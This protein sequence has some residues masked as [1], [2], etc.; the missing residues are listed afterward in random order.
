MTEWLVCSSFLLVGAA[1]FVPMVPSVLRAKLFFSLVLFSAIADSIAVAPVFAGDAT[2]SG[3]I[4]FG[5][6]LG[7]AVVGLE[8]LS[9]FF[10]MIVAW[11][12]LPAVALAGRFVPAGSG[13]RAHWFFL[14]LLLLS[15][16]LALVLD[17]LL[18]FLVV[19]EVM[20]LSSF[21][22]VL[23]GNSGQQRRSAGLHY[24]VA[25]HVSVVLLMLGAVFLP[26]GDMSFSRMSGAE[27]ALASFVL[28]MTG[29]AFKM[30]LV[31][32][33]SWIPEAY[34]AAAT[35]TSAIMSSLMSKLGVYGMLRTVLSGGFI[36][37]AAAW[38]VIVAGILSAVSGITFSVIRRDIKE[39]LSY[40]SME[41]LGII[42]TGIG[43]MMLG[44][45][46]SNACMMWA[47]LA[48]ALF[49]TLCH[50]FSKVVLFSAAGLVERAGVGRDI[51]SMGGLSRRMPR[52]SLVF[53]GTAWASASLPPFGGVISEILLVLSMV[54]G[55]STASPLA[56]TGLVLVL[57]LLAMTG[58]IA[59]LTW[60]RT[61]GIAFSGEPRS[62]AARSA[63]EGG[64]WE[65]GILWVPLIGL[66]CM[67]MFPALVLEW[68][69]PVMD[70]IAGATLF[71]DAS[72]AAWP[73][74][75]HTMISTLVSLS[76][77][78]AVFGGIVF[79]LLL[80][81]WL[82]LRKREQGEATTWSCGWKTPDSRIQY[83]ASSFSD[84][85]VSVVRPVLHTE[86]E[87]EAVSG[88]FPAS[89]GCH[90][91]D[92]DPFRKKVIGRIGVFVSGVFSRFS[93]IQSG[94][95]QQYILYGLVWLVA[96]LVWILVVA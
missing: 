10:L 25:M 69:S 9:A 85:F 48:A 63:R 30:G 21:F 32:F 66:L 2:I 20:S 50:S 61:W 45:V 93:W 76:L 74:V 7:V 78:I 79:L 57:V 53:L 16:K 83:T 71:P 39:I 4:V 87:G 34:P 3:Q 80:V 1:I 27:S 5:W 75:Q 11:F 28:L 29:F 49:K 31:P 84:P 41:N 62:L 86:R 8:R 52:V 91:H 73:L 70:T 64:V 17:S 42:T 33:H 55:L 37:E 59:L 65:A 38:L 81:R 82:L 60:T 19:W 51:E 40:S 22:L 43:L 94:N 68:V 89:A 23:M 24:F 54:A 44:S 13:A 14:G 72:L 18:H 15:M 88:Y 35:H 36:T 12:G 56:T 96:M 47:G 6:P 46:Q 77:P 90:H 92:D 26:E 58:A 95:M 67:G